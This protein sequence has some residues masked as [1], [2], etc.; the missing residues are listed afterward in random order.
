MMYTATVTSKRQITLPIKLFAD[1]AIAPGD[2]LMISRQGSALLVHRQVDL[3]DRLAGSVKLPRKYKGLKLSEVINKA[4][5]DY[6][7]QKG[8]KESK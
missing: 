1:F 6:W 2:K 8:K 5:N 7:S 4:K 3:I